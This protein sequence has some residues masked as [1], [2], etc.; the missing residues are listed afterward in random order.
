MT[1]RFVWEGIK[2]LVTIMQSL[3]NKNHD[4]RVKKRPNLRDVI[5]GRPSAKLH[6]LR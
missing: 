5:Y 1:S 6:C 3:G 2:D 4:D